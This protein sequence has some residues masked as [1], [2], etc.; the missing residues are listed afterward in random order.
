MLFHI[1]T[2]DRAWEEN[3]VPPDFGR[4]DSHDPPRL[5]Q[6]PTE[7][8]PGRCW[9]RASNPVSGTLYRW[10]VRPPLASANSLPCPARHTIYPAS[11]IKQSLK[12]TETFFLFC[13][14]F[15]K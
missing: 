3:C 11:P 6:S 12:S 4:M 8:N 9:A 1:N 10:W 7:A 15:S 14:I 13:V 5:L 2:G